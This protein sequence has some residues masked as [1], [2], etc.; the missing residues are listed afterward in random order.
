[1]PTRNVHPSDFDPRCYWEARLGAGR[2]LRAVGF[3]RLGERFNEW[4]YCVRR[5]QFV[6]CVRRV[7]ADV[8][9]RDVLDV[10][11]GTGVYVELWQQLAAKSVTGIDLTDSAL[12]GLR[13]NFPRARFLR[14]DI[15]E[16]GI[17]GMAGTFGAISAMDVLFHIVDDDRYQRALC[18]ISRLLE[19]GGVLLWTDGFSHGPERREDH[20]V[21]RSLDCVS[22][23]L[24]VAGLEVV[25]RVPFLYLMNPPIDSKSRAFVSLWRGVAAIVAASDWLGGLVGWLLYP[26]ESYL[27]RTRHESPTTELMVCRRAA[28]A[29]TEPA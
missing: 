5:A 28:E 26:I 17:D 12:I 15:G 8:H 6:R 1:V 7:A 22:R 24:D 27:V 25:E 21:I 13:R 9:E 2:N 10:G 29:A 20:V 3:Q 16:E 19:P 14:L 18:N 4:A 23:M 11:S